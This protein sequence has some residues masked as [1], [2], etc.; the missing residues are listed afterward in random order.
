MSVVQVL[1]AARLEPRQGDVPVTAE[2]LTQISLFREA[3]GRLWL[4][5]Y[6]GAL[7]LRRFREGEVVV[8]EGEPGW[9]AFY[10]LTAED[11]RTLCAERLRTA[12]EAERPALEEELAAL[13]PAEQTDPESPVLQVRL[14]APDPAGADRL[15]AGLR[16]GDLFGEMSALYQARRT[17][18]VVA[19]RPCYLLEMLGNILETLQRDPALRGRMEAVYRQQVIEQQVRR[20]GPF[21]ECSDE[22]FRR[23]SPRLELLRVEPEAALFEEH[24]RPD[25][26]YVIRQGRVVMVKNASPLLDVGDVLDWPGMAAALS[27]G[28][29][30][31]AGFRRRFAEGLPPHLW[32]ELRDG[33]SWRAPDASRAQEIVFTFNDRLLDPGL[34]DLPEVERF[35]R[36]GPLGK[37]RPEMLGRGMD[38]PPRQQRVFHRLLLEAVCGTALRPTRCGTGPHYVVS[39]HGRGD[40]VGAA[41]A[42]TGRPRLASCV[43]SVHPDSKLG[44]VEVVR[45]PWGVS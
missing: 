8:R 10:V 32:A 16:E 31:L 4:E 45:L 30:T 44:H 2:L 28:D 19:S 34:V 38:W 24:Q 43:A 42:L 22:E 29:G 14:R 36:S 33:G 11:S 7:A 18:T 21:G 6:P 26:V 37:E 23:L 27:R 3:K 17:A 35:L 5:K 40:V 12:P 13:R 25:A 15:V 1:P 9:T 41:E 20:L 39:R